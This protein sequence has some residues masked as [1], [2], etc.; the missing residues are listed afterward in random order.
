[1]VPLLRDQIMAGN[2]DAVGEM[3]HESWMLKKSLTSAISTNAID[4]IYSRARAAGALGGKLLGAGG[5][6]FL[7]FYARPERQAAV[8]AALSD[9][10]YVPFAFEHLGTRV[11]FYQPN[12]AR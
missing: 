10:R 11:A 12:R 2:S 4:E 9:M 8:K 6:G 7:V 3:L 5:G 1:M